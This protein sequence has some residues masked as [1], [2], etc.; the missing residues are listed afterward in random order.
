M[1]LME[2]NQYLKGA[3]LL[4]VPLG[5]LSVFSPGSIFFIFVSILMVLFIY[6]FSEINEK[7]FLIKIFLSGLI[8]RIFLLLGLIFILILVNHWSEYHFGIRLPFLFEDYAYHTARSWM[9]TKYYLGAPLSKAMIKDLFVAYGMTSHLYILSAFYSLF[10]FSPI[11]VTFLNC[12]FSVSTGIIYYS[13]AK[14]LFGVKAAKIT[15]VL[16]IFFPSLI[17][18]SIT[19]LKDSLFIFLTGLILWSFMQIAIYK[20]KR[21]IILLILGLLLQGSLRQGFHWTTVAVLALGYLII[22]KKFKIRYTPLLIIITVMLA[23]YLKAG[24]DMLKYKVVNYHIGVISTGGFTYKLYDNRVYSGQ[25][26]INSLSYLELV[27]GLFK[28]WFHF[29]LEP[30]PWKISSKLSLLSFP[31]MIIWY[32]L[33]LFSILG[34][35]IQLRYNWKKS[36][37]FIIYFLAI[38]SLLVLTGGNI[39]TDFRI[40]DTLTPIILLFSSIGLTKI[41]FLKYDNSHIYGNETNDL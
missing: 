21:H 24:L 32:F 28:G 11:S 20:K 13:I 22:K 23:P 5:L 4:G 38:G 36:L 35:S 6:F 18:W 1:I 41:F 16:I 17:L 25:F 8:L 31:Q 39:G 26:D 12:I 9:L 27:K 33:V 3:L 7:G 37:V 40:R 19:N 2:D 34:V 15:A 30:F 29:F 14:E 10:G